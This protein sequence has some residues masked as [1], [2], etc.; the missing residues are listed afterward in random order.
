MRV[1]PPW[2]LESYPW[3]ANVVEWLQWINGL[4]HEFQSLLVLFAFWLLWW[5]LRRERVRLGERIE[6]LRQIVTAVRDQSEEALAQP[7]GQAALPIAGGAPNGPSETLNDTRLENWEAIRALWRNARD[8]IEASIEGMLRTSMR[9]KY[10]KIPRYT[11]AD[12]IVQLRKDRVLGPKQMAELLRMDTFFN[13]AKFKPKSVTSQDVSS[14]KES[15]LIGTRGLP[16]LPEAEATGEPET[17]SPAPT[18]S[19]PIEKQS[20]LPNAAA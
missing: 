8:R 6:T 13:S 5:L 3:T 17:Y 19:A 14:F 1:I 20:V 2:V 12:V 18:V 11:Y 7:G 4:W 10:S 16:K 15:Y 9:G